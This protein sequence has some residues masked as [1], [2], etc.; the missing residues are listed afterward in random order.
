MVKIWHKAQVG[1]YMLIVA[2]DYVAI[3]T[4]NDAVVT[5]SREQALEAV[6][7]LA[8]ELEVLPR[9]FIHT[10]QG[11]NIPLNGSRT[12]DK[13]SDGPVERS[14][15]PQEARKLESKGLVADS[16]YKGPSS[17]SSAV[18][19]LEVDYSG[20]RASGH[21]KNAVLSGEMMPKADLSMAPVSN[22]TGQKVFS[23]AGEDLAVVAR[24][25][26][27]VIEQKGPDFPNV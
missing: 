23:E 1:D 13:L 4:E 24:G 22:G 19:A 8:S 21:F 6:E 2:P 16:G 17:Q 9:A 18:P 14:R 12:S 10:H 20:R 7:W 15:M 27:V 25:A 5:L 26:G 11:S 3:E